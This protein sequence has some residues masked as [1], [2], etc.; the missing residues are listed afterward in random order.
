MHAQLLSCVFCFPRLPACLPICAQVVGL[1]DEQE[2][3]A[4]VHAP[5]SLL[6]VAFPRERFL[7]ARAAALGGERGSGQCR[8]AEDQQ[9]WVCALHD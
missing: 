7:Q 5:L 6:P 1:G 3:A 4:L 9:P 2:P 8:R